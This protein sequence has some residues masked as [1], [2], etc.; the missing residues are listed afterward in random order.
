MYRVEQNRGRTL[1]YK[2][3]YQ[4]RAVKIVWKPFK[5]LKDMAADSKNGL[6]IYFFDLS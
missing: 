3:E 1:L 2:S 6:F 5:L 4:L